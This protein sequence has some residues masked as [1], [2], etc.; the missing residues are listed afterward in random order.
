M[1]ACLHAIEDIHCAALKTV[2]GTHHKQAVAFDQ[3]FQNPG[4]MTQLIR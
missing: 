2:L 4:A 3:P 1:L